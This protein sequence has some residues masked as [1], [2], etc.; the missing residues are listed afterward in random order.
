MTTQVIIR[1]THRYKSIK[2]PLTVQQHACWFRC[3]ASINKEHVV[4]LEA[5]VKT[6]SFFRYLNWTALKQAADS[7]A[8][9]ND[10]MAKTHSSRGSEK[11]R[12]ERRDSTAHRS[13]L[14]QSIICHIHKTAIWFTPEAS[15]A[16]FNSTSSLAGKTR[17]R[18]LWRH[19]CSPSQLTGGNI[20]PQ[21]EMMIK[22]WWTVWLSDPLEKWNNIF[23]S[24]P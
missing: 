7:L 21:I 11:M 4:A 22:I 10:M 16:R 18:E 15:L 24:C 17:A 2:H 1:E 6:S 5:N 19:H 20:A 13:A 14:S 3:K 12:W 23:P 9:V 8:S